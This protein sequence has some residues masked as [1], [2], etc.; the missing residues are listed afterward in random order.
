MLLKFLPPLVIQPLPATVIFHVVAKMGD[1][2]MNQLLH[3]LELQALLKDLSGL[4]LAS[5]DQPLQLLLNV[6]YLVLPL[7]TNILL[8]LTML[9]Q[10]LLPEMLPTALV[11]PH[12]KSQTLLE[13]MSRNTTLLEP[14]LKHPLDILTAVEILLILPVIVVLQI[15]LITNNT[16]PL[17]LLLLSSNPRPLDTMLLITPIKII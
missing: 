2:I 11:F 16:I 12:T 1:G 17:H 9:P 7:N 13:T 14:H 10:A 15:V 4:L 6:L 3:L 8:L 5:V